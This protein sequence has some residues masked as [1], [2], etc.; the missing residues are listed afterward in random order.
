MNNIDGRF[1][2]NGEKNVYIKILGLGD[3][4]I[5]FEPGLGSLSCEW[6]PIQHELAKHTTVITYDRPGYG[7]SP[8]SK[9][10]RT[11]KQV[12]ME[13]YNILRNSG[14][15]G[16]Y[17]LAGNSL[18]GLYHQ[19][20]TAMFPREVAGI[21]FID[22][23]TKHDVEFDKLDAPKFQE[24]ASMKSRIANISK[25]LEL[26]DEKFDNYI[27]GMISSLY[28]GFPKEL[29]DKF[30]IYQSDKKFYQTIIDEY[31]GMLESYGLPESLGGLNVPAIVLNRDFQVMIEI[32]KQIGIPEDE[33]RAVEELWLKNNRTLIEFA[34]KAQFT[35][36]KGS[37]HAIHLSRPDLLLEIL[38]NF[39][40]EFRSV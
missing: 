35:V 12:A 10:P 26:D 3:P 40:N 4:P 20:F 27:Q 1:V 24:L 16:P 21:V 37:N 19:F 29:S 5:V 17:I 38:I 23:I 6:E 11:A 13:L 22:S 39:V 32:S 14:V 33:A 34:G 25:I 28:S 30:I 8:L 18:G 9:N 7:E 36:V 2:S 15:P 31:Y